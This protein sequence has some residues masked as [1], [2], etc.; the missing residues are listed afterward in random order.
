MDYYVI[1]DKQFDSS[2]ILRNSVAN[3]DQ[4]SYKIYLMKDDISVKQAVEK[5]TT[6]LEKPDLRKENRQWKIDGS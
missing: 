1:Q 5:G 6:R 3:H 2:D 4:R